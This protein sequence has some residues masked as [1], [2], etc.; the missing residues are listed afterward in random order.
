MTD[1]QNID[2]RIKNSFEDIAHKAPAGIWEELSQ[3]LDISDSNSNIDNKIKESFENQ[4]NYAPEDVWDNVNKQLNIDKTWRRISRH[5]DRQ[6][7]IFW[8]RIA[9]AI[10]IILS[11][12]YKISNDFIVTEINYSNNIVKHKKHNNIKIKNTTKLTGE[13]IAEEQKNSNTYKSNINTDKKTG[14]HILALNKHNP[15]NEPDNT[16]IKNNTTYI[17]QPLK[18]KPK[19]PRYII[20]GN[21]RDMLKNPC[22]VVPS[23]DFFDENYR[24]KNKQYEFGIT[25]SLNNTWILNNETKKS[26]ENTSLINSHTSYTN[27]YGLLF[28]Y[29]INSNNAFTTE[30]YIHGKIQQ[31]YGMYI[32]GKYYNKQVE[33]DYSQITL[34]YQYEI[35]QIH[36]VP[37]AYSFKTGVYFS[38][39]KN[40]HITS[41]NNIVEDIADISNN[42]YGI[43]LAFGLKRKFGKLSLEYGV[44]SEYGL[45]NIFVGNSQIPSEFNETHPF[46][47]GGFVSLLYKL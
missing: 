8:S 37:S 39:F 17:Q 33:L 21:H 22:Y 42:D 12:F 15:I 28:S 9:A 26:F 6:P 14:N 10:I 30:L 27:N 44:N 35:N 34:L 25:Y 29:Y 43:K 16:L 40:R 47:I 7:I 24:K 11:L 19:Q 31:E 32:E 1:K 38:K 20:T 23:D 3:K 5:L 4:T 36:K 2:I 18:L 13:S 46:Y 45:K 41:N